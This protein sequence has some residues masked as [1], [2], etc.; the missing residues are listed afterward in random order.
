L[1]LT[2]DVRPYVLWGAAALTAGLAVKWIFEHEELHS[3]AK[4]MLGFL[5]ALLAICFVVAFVKD[6]QR[7]DEMRRQIHLQAAA[8]AFL[9]T[10]ILTFVLDGLKSAGIYGATLNDLDTATVLIWAAALIF[11]SLR[12]R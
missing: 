6:V 8:I 11:L 7:L 2:F 3:P 4:P 5:P 10:V 1:E 12:Y 9:L